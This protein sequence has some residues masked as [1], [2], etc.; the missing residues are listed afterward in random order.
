MISDLTKKG[1]VGNPNIP[2]PILHSGRG[3]RVGRVQ[4]AK[5]DEPAAIFR[6]GGN[7]P[8]GGGRASINPRQFRLE[9]GGGGCVVAG[10]LVAPDDIFLKVSRHRLLHCNNSIVCKLVLYTRRVFTKSFLMAEILKG[11]SR[12]WGGGI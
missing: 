11:V 2:T 7:L 4:S 9:C 1:I 3:S 12:G 10:S 8:N 5:Y 6:G